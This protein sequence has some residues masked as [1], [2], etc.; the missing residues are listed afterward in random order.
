MLHLP[1]KCSKHLLNKKREQSG[2]LWQIVS[3]LI[4][5]NMR[6]ILLEKNGKNAKNLKGVFT[7]VKFGV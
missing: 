6:I 2:Q 7:Q 4:F 3:P 5:K 1:L